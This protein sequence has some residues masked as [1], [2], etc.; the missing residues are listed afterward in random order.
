MSALLDITEGW[1][2]RLT[3]T[4]ET[5]ATANSDAEALDGTGL[6]LTDVIVKGSDGTAVETSGDFGWVTQDEGTVYYD[7]D[8]ADFSAALSPYSIH[9]EVTDGAGQKVYFPNGKAGEIRVH[10]A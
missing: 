9:F 4:L 2:G 7:P 3:F 8:A 6:Y 10:R 5:K 1:T